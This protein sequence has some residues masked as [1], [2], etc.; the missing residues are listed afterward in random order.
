[1][2][3]NINTLC[4]GIVLAAG[5][6]TSGHRALALDPTRSIAQMYHTT[7]SR[8]EGLPAG[9]N[10]IA[11]TPD[12]YLWVGTAGGLY[13]FDG[14]RFERI[15]AGRLLSADVTGLLATASGDLWIG[16]LGGVSRLRGDAVENFPPNA[17][18]P[19][20]NITRLKEAPHGGG[21]WAGA[22]AGPW[23]FDGRTWRPIPGDWSPD[24]EHDGALW[25]IEAA[26]DGTVWGKSGEAVYYCRP[27][28]ARFV[29]A[30]GY[31]GGVIGFARG[32][33]GRVWTSDSRER[34]HMYALPDIAGIGDD[35]VPG[36]DY[37][38]RISERIVGRILIDRD[39]TLWSRT[40]QNGLLR[41]RSVK[42][43]AGASTEVEAFTARDGLSSDQIRDLYEDREG[44]IWIATNLGLDRFRPANVVVE[45]QIPANSTHW[46]YS[47]ERAGPSLYIYS[48]TSDDYTSPMAGNRGPLYRIDSR[49]PPRLIVPEIVGPYMAPSAGGDLWLA[50]QRGLSRVHEERL[51]TEPLPFGPEDSAAWA[52]AEDTQGRL[53]VSVSG[54]GILKREHGVWSGVPLRPGQPDV[55]ASLLTADADGALW[56]YYRD[57]LVLLRYENGHARQFSPASGPNIGVVQVIRADDRGVLFGGEYGVAR[58]D[59]RGFH[60]LRTERL[61]QLSF[62]TGIAASE[63]DI[64]V[65]S[66]AGILRFKSD[67]FER[68]LA[69]PDAPLDYE[70]FEREDGLPGG[71]ALNT[72]ASSTAFPG[73]DG[74][75]YF[76]TDHGIVWIDPH[77]IYRNT[78]P[79]PVD[80]RSLSANGRIY[81]SP[82][83]IKL[84]AGS[85]NLEIDYAA[86][87]FVEPS[88]VRFRYKL[89]GVD[90]DWVDPGTRRQVFY[91]R[92]AP[93]AYRFQVIA[94]NDAG[95]WNRSGATLAFEIAPTFLQSKWFL[96][97]CLLAGAGVLWSLYA[98]RLRQITARMN[99]RFKER[100][101]ERERIAR[102][103]H[104]TL[105][106]GFQGLILRLQAVAEGV[107]A[108]PQRAYSLIE[109]ALERADAVLVEGRDRVMD[110]RAS[111]RA[112]IDMPE[113]FTRVA[114]DVQPHP[115]KVRV[116][117]E[118]M[119]RELHEIVREEVEKIGTEAIV[120]AARHAKASTIEVGITFQRHQFALRIVDDGIGIDA[121]TV[122]AGRQGH[123][124]LTGMRERAQQ[125]RGTITIASR[126]N[127]GTEIELLIPAAAAYVPRRAGIAR[128]WP[129]RPAAR[130]E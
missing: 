28:A 94:S 33:D 83:D 66:Q 96:L 59:R 39:G 113:V 40:A 105:L 8:A 109:G 23:R 119:P 41:A 47:A 82:R 11:Q 111:D 106:Q 100:V 61:P 56:I 101:A 16:Y 71:T 121:A 18:G 75:L 117:V 74:R 57:D 15:A 110:L 46:G 44:D 32:H 3:L 1:M 122:H 92:L 77:N 19:P 9:A 30:R 91:T 89:D 125:I 112:S 67:Q 29:K 107:K 126:P 58:Y 2:T 13:R 54:H 48:T 90:E 86:L 26:R 4:A 97:I 108:E 114:A 81:T 45:R 85:A 50:S 79:P 95:V 87:S 123:F 72:D 65:Q 115:A 10:A 88:R 22:N 104:D 35:A 43:G 102:E 34:G 7:F 21:I 53:W 93:G 37:G 25:S 78:L 128:F 68:V 24:W 17:G 49:S 129:R 55:T 36:P 42:A 84:P 103:L 99:Q 63:D 27:G 14:V 70:L 127:G 31:A 76:I 124:G 98:L 73:P 20:G 60:T 62:T 6:L 69:Q 38:A 12:G 130:G 52:V 80:I 120:N 116:T 51:I 64:W 118:G 5:L